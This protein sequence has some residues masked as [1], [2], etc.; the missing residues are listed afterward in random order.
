MTDIITV[1][2]RNQRISPQKARLVMNL[3]RLKSVEQ[4]ET[5]IRFMDKKAAKMIADL[6]NSAVDAAKNKDFKAEDLQISQAICTDGRKLKR[7]HPNA[8]GRVNVFKK[9][10]S[11]FKISL[12]EI[13]KDENVENRRLK[14]MKRDKSEIDISSKKDGKEK[15]GS[16][17]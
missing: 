14:K 9:R 11:H 17:S 6:L 3:I 5:Q 12:S 2:A 13:K 7:N 8:K 15:N 10:M 16:E 4:A 1:T